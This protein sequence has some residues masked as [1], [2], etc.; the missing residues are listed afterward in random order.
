MTTK[1]PRSFL[2][3][4]RRGTRMAPRDG[5]TPRA[6]LIDAAPVDLTA[7]RLRRAQEA[8]KAPHEREGSTYA[9]TRYVFDALVGVDTAPDAD[10]STEVLF[11][12]DGELAALGMSAR[13]AIRLGEALIEAGKSAP[14][15]NPKPTTEPEGA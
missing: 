15:M 4:L 9:I 14:S 12:T 7:E 8:A 11:V 10:R 6:Q 3:E 2:G 5:F 1:P 13:D